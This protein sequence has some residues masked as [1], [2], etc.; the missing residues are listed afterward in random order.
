MKRSRPLKFQ[1][2]E[3]LDKK[4]QDYFNSCF[5]DKWFDVEKRSKKGKLL[6]DKNGKPKT[7]P[8]LKKVQIKPI[9]ITGLAVALNTSRQ[10]LLNYEEKEIYFDTIK[11]A[12]DFI[13]NYVEDGMLSGKIPVAGAIFNLLNNWGGWVN[14]TETKQE[15]T[16]KGLSEEDKNKLDK[17]FMQDE[18]KTINPDEEIKEETTAEEIPSEG[19]QQEGQQS[20]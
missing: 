19:Q 17:L 2:L 7:T 4:I 1:S 6:L 12:K 18:T 3:E 15:H 16:I 14:R 20:E 5:E 11:K 8:I 9:S 13:E 10:T